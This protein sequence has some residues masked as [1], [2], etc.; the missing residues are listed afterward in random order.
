MLTFR[1]LLDFIYIAQYPTHDDITLS[2]LED[3]LKVY[4]KNKKILKTLGICTHM[5][6]P[7]FHSLLYYIESIHSLGTTDNYNTEMPPHRLR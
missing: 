7:K 3:A 6:I 5:N 2:Y 4:H 1:S